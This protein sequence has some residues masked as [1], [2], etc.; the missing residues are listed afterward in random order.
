MCA[1]LCRLG[2]VCTI[3][4]NWNSAMKAKS[5]APSPA[6]LAKRRERTRKR[7]LGLKRIELWID[8]RIERTVRA[9]IARAFR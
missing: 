3:I 2:H 5:P 7:K 9:A 4:A 1:A 8:P 6:A